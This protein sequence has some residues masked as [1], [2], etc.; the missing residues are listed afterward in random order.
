[1][2]QLHVYYSLYFMSVGATIWPSS[3]WMPLLWI[4]IEVKFSC[5]GTIFCIETLSLNIFKSMEGND[6]QRY[7]GFNY[8]FLKKTETHKSQA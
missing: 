6:S 2:V 1:M 8:V 3:G 7:T 4:V 5:M